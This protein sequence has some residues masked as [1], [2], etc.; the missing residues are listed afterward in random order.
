M[1]RLTGRILCAAQAAAMA[2]AQSAPPAANPLLNNGQALALYTRSVQLIES[3]M[4]AVPD[5]AAAGAPLL[6]RVKESLAELRVTP[7]NAANQYSLL[8]NVRAYVNLSDSVP[9]P[10]QF[11]EEGQRQFHELRDSVSK[12]ETHF[13]ALIEQKDRQLRNPDPDNLT[14]YAEV[15]SRLGPPAAG[16]PRVVFLGDS[17]TDFW[18]L[19]EYFPDR[20]F[21]NR[22]I[23]GQITSQM[24]G[25][26]K[27]DVIDLHPTAVVIL[28][29]T[30]DIARGTSLSTIESNL[31][32]IA[33]L[34]ERHNIKVVM[35]TVLPV[36]D[37]HKDVNPA[38]EVTKQ[39]PPALIR[40]LNNWM[41]GFCVQRNYVFLD[42]YSETVDAS[43]QIKA[44][45]ADDGL[46]PN[47][48]GYRIMAPLALAAVNK[49]LTAV[50][51]AQPQQTVRKRR[52]FA[53]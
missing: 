19:N 52:L 38:W 20:D 2:M 21:V 22:G 33:D 45:L 28:A 49:T 43:G 14:R 4:V 5:L 29:G 37:Y 48:A 10:T 15:D 16:R 41:Q 6:G 31:I 18:R 27:Q 44:E 53:R 9:K 8:I 34:C 11:A 24:L 12:I 1:S 17:I 50:A 46:H 35:S 23:S 3:T 42:Y 7:G 39:R 47:S 32:L 26:M 25:R 40:A 36:S 51:A 13:R 30:N